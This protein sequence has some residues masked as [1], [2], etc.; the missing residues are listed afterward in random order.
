MSVLILKSLPLGSVF[1]LFVCAFLLQTHDFY[2]LV[3]KGTDMKGGAGG[4]SGTG[5]VEIKVVD[6]NDNIPT[7]EKSEVEMWF[8]LDTK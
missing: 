6:I 3:V 8:K 4:K 2:K 7:L 5:T 1:M